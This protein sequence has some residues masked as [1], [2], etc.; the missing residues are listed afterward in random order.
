MSKNSTAK[1]EFYPKNPQ[2]YQGKLPIIYRSSWEISVMK[3]YDEH[4]YVLAWKS[5]TVRI[6]YINPFTK[7]HTVYIPDFLVQFADTSGKVYVELVEVKP[8]KETPGYQAMSE[9]T[10]RPLKVNKHTQMAQA[11]NFV[12]WE[13]AK[14]YCKQRGWTFRV[15]TEQT[16]YAMNMP[17]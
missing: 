15:V 5:E 11:L 10:G 9:R 3:F 17:K 8:L 1:G 6:P 2:K 14:L 16:L 4:P 7:K 13:V 12:K